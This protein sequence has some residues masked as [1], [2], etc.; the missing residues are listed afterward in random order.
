MSDI[1]LYPEWLNEID[2]NEITENNKI[3]GS[4]GFG[5][6][7]LEE[8]HKRGIKVALKRLKDEK[9]IKEFVKEV[10]KFLL[11]FL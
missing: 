10:C 3:I 11:I 7:T 2:Y 4:G 5:V 8:W 6:V 1:D 9:F